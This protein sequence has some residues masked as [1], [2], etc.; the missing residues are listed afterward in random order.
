MHFKRDIKKSEVCLE[1]SDFNDRYMK[2]E[3]EMGSLG[4]PILTIKKILRD[5][6]W[7]DSFS[8]KNY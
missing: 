8:L 2:G 4:L 1:N 5:I 7:K 3:M 6:K